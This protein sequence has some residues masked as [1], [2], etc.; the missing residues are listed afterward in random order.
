MIIIDVFIAISHPK[1][2]FPSPPWW[3]PQGWTEPGAWMWEQG[4]EGTQGWHPG[5]SGG[6]RG[7][8]APRGASH[9][10]DFPAGSRGAASSQAH[11]AGAAFPWQRCGM[12]EMK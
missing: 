5:V 9:G 1:A 7:G 2:A 10:A 3:N 6:A 4:S 12:R 11:P 8:D